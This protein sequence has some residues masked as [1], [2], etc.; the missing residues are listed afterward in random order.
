MSRNPRLPIAAAPVICG[1]R[2][3][4]EM[5]IRI[6]PSA[7]HENRRMTMTFAHAILFVVHVSHSKHP[8]FAVLTWRAHNSTTFH[9]IGCPSRG[10]YPTLD[11]FV[12]EKRTL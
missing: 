11:P 9:T 2:K 10:K 6:V 7:L 3:L 1:Q 4:T 8:I 12:T 5:R